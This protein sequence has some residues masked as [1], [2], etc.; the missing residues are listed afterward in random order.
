MAKKAMTQRVRLAAIF[1][2]LAILAVGTLSLLENMSLDYYS[3]LGTLKKVIPASI[4]L[5]A[6]G[7]VMGMILDRPKRKATVNYQNLLLNKDLEAQI[8][9]AEKVEQKDETK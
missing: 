9:E 1:A 2:S 7:W 3:V 5:G 8:I 6:L 4:I